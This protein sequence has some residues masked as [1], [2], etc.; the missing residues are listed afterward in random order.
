MYMSALFKSLK[1]MKIFIEK[2]MSAVTSKLVSD[3]K[4][5]NNKNM[6]EKEDSYLDFF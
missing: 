4:Y 1:L 5:C 3:T 6:R 2:L